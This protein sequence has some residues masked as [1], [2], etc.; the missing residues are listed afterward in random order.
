MQ[1]QRAHQ[2]R[3]GLLAVGA[4]FDGFADF[5]FGRRAVEAAV[6]Q[7]RQQLARG[8][9]RWLLLQRA[10]DLDDGGFVVALLIGA[11][12]FLQQY[13]GLFSAAAGRHGGHRQ[14][15]DGS[16]DELANNARHGLHLSEMVP[17]EYQKLSFFNSLRITIFL[18]CTVATPSPP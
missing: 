2:H 14:G 17:P 9:Q 18:A 12:R 4:Q 10:L 8:R 1:Q 15:A 16:K 5:L 6:M 7:L 3:L 13:L 11:L